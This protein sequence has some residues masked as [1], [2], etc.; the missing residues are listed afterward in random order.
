[1]GAKIPRLV[2][3]ARN[4]RDGGSKPPPYSEAEITVGAIH[5]SPASGGNR[6][7]PYSEDGICRFVNNAQKPGAFFDNEDGESGLQTDGKMV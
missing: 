3:L 4:D 5:E 6:H 2:A 7:G 1:M